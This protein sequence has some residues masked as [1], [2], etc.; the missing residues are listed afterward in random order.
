MFGAAGVVGLGLVRLFNRDGNQKGRRDKL[1]A[2]SPIIPS[3]REPQS[4]L[5][6]IY[7]SPLVVK[8]NE[9]CAHPF[10]QTATFNLLLKVIVVLLVVSL[11][12]TGVLSVIRER[13][14]HWRFQDNEDLA[15]G[16]WIIDN[17]DPHVR[18]TRA[19]LAVFH[20]G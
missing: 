3:H 15:T 16:Q 6:P 8:L 5:S 14:L 17:T 12:F 11:C 18:D 13:N 2:P 7:D 10:F 20:D 4:L 9:F 19:P 1:S